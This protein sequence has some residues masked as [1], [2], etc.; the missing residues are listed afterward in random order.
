MAILDASVYVALLRATEPAHEQSWGW[1]QQ[2]RQR[3]ERLLA[4]ALL[5]PEVAAAISRGSQ[6]PLLARRVAELLT[7]FSL[8]ELVAVTPEL[9]GHA[10]SIAADHRL[11]GSDAVYVALAEELGQPLVTLDRQQLERGSSVVTTRAP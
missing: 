10:A 3:G 4:P 8:I 7:R 1:V 9:A 11:R 6:K 5:L 2:A